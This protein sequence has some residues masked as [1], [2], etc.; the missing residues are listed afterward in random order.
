M[1]I[2]DIPTRDPL[3]L[4]IMDN[5]MMNVHTLEILSID[6]GQIENEVLS[7]YILQKKLKLLQNLSNAK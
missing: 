1:Y 6:S 7:Q 4:I 3:Y 2:V 5:G